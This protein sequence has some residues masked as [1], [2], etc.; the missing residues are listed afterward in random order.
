[1]LWMT[2]WLSALIAVLAIGISAHTDNTN[3]KGVDVKATNGFI[4][5]ISGP[6]DPD[7]ADVQEVEDTLAGRVLGDAEDLINDQLPEGWQAK[8]SEATLV[9]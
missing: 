2:A 9:R 6:D 3:P 4:I 8:I 7:E 1:M 5:T